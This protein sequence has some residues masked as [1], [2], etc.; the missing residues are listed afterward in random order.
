MF[1]SKCFCNFCQ[2]RLLLYLSFFKETNLTKHRYN[3]LLN[4]LF[5]SMQCYFYQ[6]S[7]QSFEFTLEMTR[8]IRYLMGWARIFPSHHTARLGY[9]LRSLLDN[10][11]VLCVLYSFQEILETRRIVGDT[12]IYSDCSWVNT[13][14]CH[15][16]RA[17]ILW[18]A[19][20]LPLQTFDSMPYWQCIIIT[21]ITNLS[22][23]IIFSIL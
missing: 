16:G 4:F 14:V 13:L 12:I 5:C 1:I 9:F 2:I 19:F 6:D 3:R 17:C 18:Y 21:F 10:C 22:Q 15:P 11:W 8:P 23:G 20:Q 7:S